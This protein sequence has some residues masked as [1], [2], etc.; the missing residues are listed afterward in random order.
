MEI[1]EI[2]EKLH[3]ALINEGIYV[4]DDDVLISEYISDSIAFVSLIV[5]IECQFD[6]AMPDEILD[7]ERLGSV[8]SLC[9][10]ISDLISADKIDM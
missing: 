4:D 1:N 2:R 7:F 8:N 3:Y 5:Q 10:Y 6:V 9:V